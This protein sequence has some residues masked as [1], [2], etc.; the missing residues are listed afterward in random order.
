M[1]IQVSAIEQPAPEKSV[2][3]APRPSSSMPGFVSNYVPDP[4]PESAPTLPAKVVGKQPDSAYEEP[5]VMMLQDSKFVR[6]SSKEVKNLKLPEY[7][8]LELD[9]TPLKAG[10]TISADRNSS[11]R[12]AGKP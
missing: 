4:V 6:L 9:F 3:L 11:I 5:P 1:K 12:H 2:S 10:E 7:L 8:Q